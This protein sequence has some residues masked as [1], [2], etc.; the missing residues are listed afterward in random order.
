MTNGLVL[1]FTQIPVRVCQ[2]T[3]ESCAVAHVRKPQCVL[4]TSVQPLLSS[5]L[6][7]NPRTLISIAPQHL[8][9]TRI[10]PTY[11]PSLLRCRTLWSPI[12]SQQQS[13]I[14]DNT[15]IQYIHKIRTHTHGTSSP[16]VSTYVLADKQVMLYGKEH[17]D[18]REAQCQSL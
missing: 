13:T 17:P 18:P 11:V 1:D 5:C 6:G 10:Q 7:D 2:A 14:Q 12:W 8:M 9:I 3:V 4:L 15:H 16:Q